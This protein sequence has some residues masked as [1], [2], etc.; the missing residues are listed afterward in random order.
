MTTHTHLDKFQKLRATLCASLIERESEIDSMI[1]G[2]VAQEHVLLVGPPGTAKSTLAHN[3]QAAMTDARSFSVL[4]TKYTTPEELFGP[5]KLSALRADK[6]ERN[7]EGFAPT[8]EIVFIDEIWKASSAILNTTL[9][10][11]QERR[12]AQGPTWIDC[13]LQIGMA[14]SNEWPSAEESQELG[15]VFDRFLIRK[16]VR[17]VSPSGRDRLL[18]DTLPAVQQCGITPAVIAEASSMAA[19]L[20]VSDQAR[21]CMGKI[22]DELAAEG[23][24]PGDRRARKAIGIARAAAWL[25]GSGQV[26]PSHLTPLSDVLWQSPEQAEKAAEIVTRVANPIM[27]ALNEIIREADEISSNAG[28]DSANQMAAIKQLEKLQE[29]TQKI[30]DQGGNGRAQQTLR[31]VKKERAR[32]SAAAMGIDPEKAEAMLGGVN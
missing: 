18:Y 11:L 1:L 32:L 17:P 24:R 28:T 19:V 26:L 10:L 20:P 15:A 4:L 22:L 9:T 27:A 23:I 12:F 5:V 7:I 16:T 25:M 14:A 30:V 6:Y 21:V 2:L 31:H 13:P 8:S 29:R 3:L